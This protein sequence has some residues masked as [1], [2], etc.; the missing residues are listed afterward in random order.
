MANLVITNHQERSIVI[1]G[2]QYN[3]NIVLAAGAVTY[4]AGTLLGRITASGKLTAYTSGAADGS[5]IP[6]AVLREELVF[7]GAGEVSAK[8]IVEGTLDRDLMVAHGV[9]AITIAEADLLRDFAIV[10][11]STEQLAQLDNQ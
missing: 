8:V 3:A 7:A 6:L 2:A 9:G 5:E 10:T 1:F 4:V 11:Q